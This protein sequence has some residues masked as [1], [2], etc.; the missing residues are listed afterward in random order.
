MVSIKLE[1]VVIQ[2]MLLILGI[3]YINYI[4]IF[5]KKTFCLYKLLITYLIKFLIYVIPNN[6]CKILI[7]LY[8]FHHIMLFLVLFKIFLIDKHYFFPISVWSTI[9]VDHIFVN[10]K[11]VNS[12]Y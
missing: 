7:M 5:K 2:K 3:F 12:F 11:K 8:E 9:I 1:I 10:I 4:I 6:A